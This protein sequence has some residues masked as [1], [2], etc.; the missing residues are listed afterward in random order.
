MQNSIVCSTCKKDQT[1]I[2]DEVTGEIVCS[3]CGLVISDKILDTRQEWRDFLNTE[4]AK[5]RRRTGM[6]TSLA[7]HDMGL[8][9][10]IGRGHKDAR[11]QE[12]DASMRSTM[13]RLRT[14]DLRTQ[15]S[16]S[17]NLGTAFNQLNIL[18]DKLG[19]PDAII[20]KTAYIY[21]KARE[22]GLGRGRETSAVLAAALYLACREEGTPR[23]LNEICLISN[24]K[25]KAISQP[26]RDMPIKC[27]ARI[28]NQI[29]LSQKIKQ[30]AINIMNAA[31]KSE[32]SAG[33]SPM[34]LAAS[35]LYLS[36][37]ING[38]NN[39]SQIVFAQTAGVTEV[40]I[41]NISKDLR[42]HLDLS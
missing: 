40:T 29:N 18:K 11:G 39:I 25:R 26:Y 15:A 41:R 7:I 1:I 30:K 38:C 9:T 28:A 8:Y 33:K 10:M 5:D 27:I 21:R 16:A 12:L 14:W 36:C 22:R 42:N 37:L 34:G 32:L 19:L 20:E 13:G 24:L 4:E 31:T 17:R 35:I 23:T 3:K 6:P 2:T